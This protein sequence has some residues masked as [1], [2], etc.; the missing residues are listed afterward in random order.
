MPSTFTLCHACGTPFDRTDTT[1]EVR[2]ADPDG[3]LQIVALMCGCVPA[4]RT[5]ADWERYL[6]TPDGDGL[7][8]PAEG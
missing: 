1:R 3:V 8:L 7:S 6:T 4:G 5:R 2:T